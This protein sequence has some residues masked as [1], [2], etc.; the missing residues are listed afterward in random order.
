MRKY[1]TKRC[2]ECGEQFK[3]RKSEVK[4]GN[5][6]F[7]SISCATSFNNK[8]RSEKR[9]KRVQ[10]NLPNWTYDLSYIVGLIT[11]DGSLLRE[12]PRIT[13]TSAD[14]EL[15]KIVKE[16]V[17]RLF[18]IN[19]CQPY[20]YNQDGST[21]WH[22]QFTCWKLYYFLKNIGILPNKSKTIKKVN[23]PNE[24]F[25]DFLRGEIDGD[26]GFYL[27]KGHDIL[28]TGIFSGSENFIQ[29]LLGKI[30]SL[31]MVRGGSIKKREQ[32]FTLTFGVHDTQKIVKYIYSDNT[33]CLTRK[34]QIAIQFFDR[35][36]PKKR[37]VNKI[38]N[39]NKVNN[40]RKLNPKKGIN[41]LKKYHEESLT[42]KELANEYNVGTCTIGKVINL[43]HW[44]TRSL[45]QKNKS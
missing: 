18:D 31:V 13:F 12:K 15:I 39:D 8:K 11:S 38:N 22:Y 40:D 9:K 33:I 24:Y 14:F 10:E 1:I 29:W 36:D 3:V 19:E 2:K 27:N 32:C 35:Y 26:G 42:I 23:V 25:S 34:K 41:I 43:K 6:L 5:G 7:C 21:F 44:T 30:K 37:K 4:R 20:K 28:T 45:K 16:T 17:E